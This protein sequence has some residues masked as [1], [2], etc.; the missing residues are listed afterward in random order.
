MEGEFRPCWW[1]IYRPRYSSA[2]V[3]EI[4]YL[5]RGCRRRRTGSIVGLVGRHRTCVAGGR[6]PLEVKCGLTPRIVPLSVLCYLV[7]SDPNSWRQ[8]DV[9]T[10]FVGR[11]HLCR[12]RRSTVGEPI[13][14]PH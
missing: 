8:G 3:R 5:G 4:R 11:V 9:S 2:R 13:S 14:F 12:G 7:N 1:G 6:K 10:T